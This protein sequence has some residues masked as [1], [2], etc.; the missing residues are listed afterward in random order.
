[1]TSPLDAPRVHGSPGVTVVAR[2]V[3]APPPVALAR[4][5]R[6]AG[7]QTVIV[8]ADP[9][10]QVS[11]L[12]QLLAEHLPAGCR[13][14]RLVLSHAGRPEVAQELAER[15]HL[16]VVAPAGRVLLLPSGMLFASDGGQPG[17]GWPGGGWP[18]GWYTFRPGAPAAHVGARHPAPEWQAAVPTGRA[19]AGG[20]RVTSIPA[21]LWLHESEPVQPRLD[22]PILS[23]PVLPESRSVLVG[24]PRRPTAGG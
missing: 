4:I 11:E 16:E 21:G 2:R 7:R 10:L 3:A 22:G 9:P 13:S 1:M 12:V 14:V 17:G 19:T 5:A 8:A 24:R 20:L 23:V 15:L 6:E 18:G